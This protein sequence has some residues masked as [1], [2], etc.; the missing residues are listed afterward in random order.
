MDTA[1]EVMES[2]AIDQLDKILLYD[3]VCVFCNNSVD[4]VLEHERSADIT[5]TPLQSEV[6]KQILRKFDYPEDYLGSILYLTNGKLLAKSSAALAVSKYLKA[7][8]S[9]LQVFWIVPKFLRDFVY[10]FI[11]RNRYKWF[12]QYDACRMPTP[13]LR[14]RFLE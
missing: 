11:G 4:F 6:G 5:F 8:I 1:E 7:P 13:S 9:W 10:D 12:G 3:G 14:K 2:I